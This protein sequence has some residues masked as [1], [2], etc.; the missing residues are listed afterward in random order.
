MKTRHEQAINALPSEL[1]DFF[2]NVVGME[3]FDGRLSATQWQALLDASMLDD[4]QARLALLPLAASFS[5]APVSSFFVGAI[6]TGFSGTRY[7]GANM[8]F[9]GLGMSQTVHAE[10]SAIAH[11]WS[12]GE[13]G[14]S[15]ITINYSPCG[16]CRQFMN[17]LTQAEQLE[18]QLPERQ[19]M[20]LHDYLPESFG[21]SDLGQAEGLMAKTTPSFTAES[22][23]PLVKA[24]LEAAALSHAPYSKNL[25]GIALQTRNG[26]I[27]TGRYAENAA[28]NPS[29]PPLQVA[30]IQMNMAG[31]ALADIQS[32]C[33]VESENGLVSFLGDCQQLLD[34]L[35]PDA[36]FE[37]IT[38]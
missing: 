23:S 10:Q 4:A 38:L 27:Y 21:P 14:I 6:V 19:A 34:K 18:I 8:E 12:Y 35:C 29:L 1:K 2:V 33:M 5:I 13:T 16:H 31:E 37:Y 26:N 20:A 25:S 11:A 36:P 15:N 17:E 30:L 7:F 24:A 9:H 3:T 32:A 28:F 22:D